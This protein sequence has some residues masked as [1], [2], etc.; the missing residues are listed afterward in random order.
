MINH[1]PRG[2]FNLKISKWLIP[3]LIIF[4]IFGLDMKFI[5][6]FF[7][8]ALHEISHLV[9]VKLM[10]IETKELRLH[11]LGATLE[12]RD[13]NT[14]SLKE[15]IIICLAGPVFNALMSLMF[16][17]MFKF[18]GNDFFLMIVEVNLALAIFNIMPMYPLDGF[19]LLLSFLSLRLSYVKANKVSSVISYIVNIVLIILSII[20]LVYKNISGIF[21]IIICSFSI[22]K[23]FKDRKNIMYTVM[24]SL[25]KKQ[26]LIVRKRYM[27]T[28]SISVYWEESIIDLI[29]VLQKDKFHIFYILDKNMRVVYV[30]KED[31]FMDVLNNY[32]NIKLKD[33]YNTR[34]K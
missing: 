27:K 3:Q 6:C 11:C 20:F 17:T 29:K 31:E 10:N 4:F 32:G 33:Y 19:K 16:F 26:N 18:F 23:T 1:K 14:L 5:I 2:G 24:E 15:Q 25:F 7:F 28:K 12:I 9:V 22:F 13:Y 30:L 21:I 34:N 8:I